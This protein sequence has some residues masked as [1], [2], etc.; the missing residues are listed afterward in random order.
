M[1]PTPPRQRFTLT[2]VDAAPDALAPPERRLARL[3]K[4]LLRYYGFRCERAVEVTTHA[5]EEAP[6]N[7]P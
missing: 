1:T 7:Q 6:G 2:L 3:L 4:C 5:E